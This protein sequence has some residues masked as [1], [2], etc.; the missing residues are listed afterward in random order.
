MAISI[1]GLASFMKLPHLLFIVVKK[2]VACGE[3]HQ[4]LSLNPLSNQK[5]HLI[6]R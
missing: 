6:L 1:K 2:E 4:S 3:G 5:K